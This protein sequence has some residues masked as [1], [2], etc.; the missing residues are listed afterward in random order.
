MG[1][2]AQPTRAQGRPIQPMDMQKQSQSRQM[3][4]HRTISQ[5]QAYSTVVS[6]ANVAGHFSL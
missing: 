2:R 4:N 6:R 5:G 1:A 3:E